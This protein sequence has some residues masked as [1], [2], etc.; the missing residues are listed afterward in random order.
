MQD[1]MGSIERIEVTISDIQNGNCPPVMSDLAA[2][3]ASELAKINSAEKI[4]NLTGK[5]LS[6]MSI[7][8]REQ[9]VV[10]LEE[11]GYSYNPD[12]NSLLRI[13]IYYEDPDDPQ[14]S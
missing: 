4:L 10:S 6:E 11:H 1:N 3:F 5:T 8:R 12:T 7:E 9:L 13:S 14:E 2:S